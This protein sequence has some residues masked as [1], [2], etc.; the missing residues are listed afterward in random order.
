MADH[1]EET[2]QT[3]YIG[4][5]PYPIAIW[6][7][8]GS[9]DAP[10]DI[11]ILD[12]RSNKE[13][14]DLASDLKD[15]L[16]LQGDDYE[17]RGFP[18]TLLDAQQELTCLE[19]RTAAETRLLEN[20]A[21]DIAMS[22]LP[23]T[24]IIDIG[25]GSLQQTK[26]LLEAFESHHKIVDYYAVGENWDGLQRT[27]KKL[28]AGRFNYVR[29]HGLLGTPQDGRTWIAKYE[30]KQR[31]VCVLSLGSTISNI[32]REETDA[33]WRQW[34][35]LLTVNNKFNSNNAR[36][37][38]GLE[39]GKESSSNTSDGHASDRSQAYDEQNLHRLLVNANDQLGIKAFEPSEW[40]MTAEWD[41]VSRP[42]A[43]FLVP[44][45]DVT[46]KD[47]KLKAGEKILVARSYKYS[48]EDTKEMLRNSKLKELQRY[49]DED[50]H[51]GV[52]VLA[53]C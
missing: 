42:Y 18:A 28:D 41:P 39:S 35:E 27:L 40:I 7:L 30:N 49:T 15:K 25:F 14:Q 43:N 11:D 10:K 23:G 51:Y 19:E 48:D 9:E 24:I 33:F 47:V 26:T 53:P 50:G 29:C 22:L 34:S 3:Q 37:I 46:L 2:M 12:I 17:R 8:A 44:K 16:Q 52:Y 13:E 45:K 6:P 32:T 4:T 21:D 5:Y 20:H 36:I 31:P 38:V 1:V